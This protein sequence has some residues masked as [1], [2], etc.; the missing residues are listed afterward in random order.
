MTSEWMALAPVGAALAVAGCMSGFLAGLLGIGGGAV[1]VITLFETFG[2]VGV[3]PAIR[4]HLATGTSLAVLLPTTLTSFR[5]HLAKGAVDRPLL[6]RLAP[7][8]VGGVVLGVL[9]ARYSTGDALKWVWVT[10]GTFLAARMLLGRDDWRLGNDI[11]KSR[12]VEVYAGFVGFV[13]SLMSVGGGALITLLMSLYNRPLHQAVATSSGLGPVIALPAVAGFVWAGWGA[14][15]LPPMSL[16][17]VSVIGA[18]LVI[19]FGML[20][21]PVGARL[22]HRMKKRHLELAFAVFMSAVVARYL[23]AL[24]A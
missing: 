17:Y 1:V 7:A 23:V 20:A 8:V 18:A 10:M 22:A 11:P 5:A 2:L 21:A 24:L 16:G 6:R 9:V 14:P 12:L 4:M 3:D 15:G 19:P 13:S